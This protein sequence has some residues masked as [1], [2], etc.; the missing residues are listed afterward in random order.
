MNP[1]HTQHEMKPSIFIILII[2]YLCFLISHFLVWGFFINPTSLPLIPEPF[3]GLDIY[4]GLPSLMGLNFLFVYCYA[5]CILFFLKKDRKISPIFYWAI[6]ILYIIFSSVF[7]IWTLI[8]VFLAWD[9]VYLSALV[10][11][12]YFW[13]FSALGNLG[14]LLYFN[15]TLKKYK[16]RV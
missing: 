11:G 16:I 12:F 13:L 9:W 14:M 10:F 7:F 6:T 1:P 2:S 5:A 4:S 3:T 8:G 15:F